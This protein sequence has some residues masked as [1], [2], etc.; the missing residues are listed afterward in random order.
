MEHD[1]RTAIITGGSKGIG[2]ATAEIMLREGANVVILDKDKVQSNTL[3][4]AGEKRVL[5]IRCDVSVEKEVKSAI[6][7]AEQTFGQINYLVNNAGIQRYSTVTE[8]SEEEWDLVMNVNLKSA[9]L[10]AKHAIPYMQK[11]GRGVVVN[12]SSVQAMLSQNNVAP[13]TTSKTAMLGLTRSIAV[14]Y[15]P[16][17]RCVAVCPGTVDTPMLQWGIKQSPNPEQVYQE[18][19]DMHLT[20]RVGQPQ[21]IGEFIA[22]LCSDKAAFMT[23]QVYR[24]DGGLGVMIPGSKRD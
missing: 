21:E 3:Q 17:I 13:Y 9:F 11:I 20:E 10:C 6:A 16:T 18:C 22:Y 8:T 5:L 7:Q 23:G 2:R 24:I 1:R 4:E 12:V 14:D 15:A 19:V